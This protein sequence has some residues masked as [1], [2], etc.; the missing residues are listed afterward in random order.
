MAKPRRSG[1]LR[2]CSAQ[3]ASGEAGLALVRHHRRRAPEPEPDQHGAAQIEQGE[4]V[5]VGGEAEMVGDRRRQQAPEQVAGD[6]AGDVGGERA[7]GVD[8]TAALAEIGQGQRERRRHEHAL[9]HPQGGEGGEVRRGR[10]QR[11]RDGEQRQADDDAGAAV[12]PPA[13]VGDHQP[14][15]RHADRAGVDGEAHRGRHDPVGARQR[16]QDGLGREQVDHGQ[17][18]DQAD[19]QVAA[20]GAGGVRGGEMRRGM[21]VAHRG[22]G[23]APGSVGDAGVTPDLAAGRHGLDRTAVNAGVTSCARRRSDAGGRRRSARRWSCR[24]SATSAT[25]PWSPRRPRQG[26]GRSARRSCWRTR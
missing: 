14:R 5:E 6:V 17:E 26:N 11:G 2:R 25:C 16:R 21:G 9:R 22:H 24:C 8:G 18:G 20:E 23:P 19:H 7:G 12:D 1:A 4:D 3:V 13:E 10:E 15:H